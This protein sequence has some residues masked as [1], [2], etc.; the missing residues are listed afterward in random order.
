MINLKLEYSLS[1]KYV[2]Q[3]FIE[4]G[5][6]VPSQQQLELD[7]TKLSSNIRSSLIKIVGDLNA[8]VIKLVMH[9]PFSK[10]L[11]GED[12]EKEL[13]WLATVAHHKIPNNLR[14][15]FVTIERF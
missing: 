12:I 15:L 10:S 7:P 11:K 5:L 2:K 9:K 14:N 4:T 8:Q 1:K 6:V 3:R 13:Q